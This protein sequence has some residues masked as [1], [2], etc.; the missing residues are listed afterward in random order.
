M[1]KTASMPVLLEK[2][3]LIDNQKN[4]THVFTECEQERLSHPEVP[5]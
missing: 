5:K 1:L 3:L 2:E 4:P